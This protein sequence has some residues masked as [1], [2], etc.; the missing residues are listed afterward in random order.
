MDPDAALRRIIELAERAVD[1]DPGKLPDY[2]TV[3]DL[4]TELA[5]TVLGL[6]EWIRK[7][8]FLPEDW[9]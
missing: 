1:A 6:D 3:L 5:E 8:G 7:G 2:E 4:A 9:R